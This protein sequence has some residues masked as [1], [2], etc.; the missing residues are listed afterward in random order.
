LL[1]GAPLPHLNDNYRH[2]DLLFIILAEFGSKGLNLLL[3]VEFLL[4]NGFTGLKLVVYHL[5]EEVFPAFPAL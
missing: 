1:S 4:S 2:S 3:V 5:D